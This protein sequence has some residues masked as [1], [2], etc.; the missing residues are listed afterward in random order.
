MPE[1]SHHFSF[2]RFGVFNRGFSSAIVIAVRSTCMR[3]V[4]LAAVAAFT[5]IGEF[6]AFLAVEAVALHI[7]CIGGRVILKKVDYKCL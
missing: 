7:Y 3:A 5:D 6:R 2:K 1:C 4:S